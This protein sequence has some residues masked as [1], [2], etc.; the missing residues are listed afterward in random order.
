MQ[1]YLSSKNYISSVKFIVV[2]YSVRYHWV[3]DVI[4]INLSPRY[5]CGEYEVFEDAIDII[6]ILAQEQS[7]I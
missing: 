3:I 6:Q 5:K 2:N 7:V 4:V 1:F